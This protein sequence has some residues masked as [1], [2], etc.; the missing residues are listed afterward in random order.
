MGKFSSFWIEKI[1][2]RPD[3]ASVLM[4]VGAFVCAVRNTFPDEA[5]VA[6]E[7]RDFRDLVE[8]LPKFQFKQLVLHRI[9][10]FLSPP[11]N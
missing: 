10:H 9:D 6:G 4:C 5:E 11:E 2:D 7:L 3:A 8:R 1:Q